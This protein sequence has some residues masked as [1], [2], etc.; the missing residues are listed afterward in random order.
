MELSKCVRRYFDA[1][2]AQEPWDDPRSDHF[3]YLFVKAAVRY[4]RPTPRR[5]GICALIIEEWRNR[6]VSD[7]QELRKHVDDLGTLYETL[8]DYEK[9]CRSFPDRL[10]EGNTR[11]NIASFY[12]ALSTHSGSNRGHVERRMREEYGE[13]WQ[14]K[15]DIDSC[16]N[17]AMERS[18]KGEIGLRD[19]G[20]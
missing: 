11:K 5:E 18:K 4:S 3:F 10:I 1:W 15:M 19:A 7:D 14:T 20:A 17:N 9:V 8:L 13:H 2:M 12:I 16:I 6:G